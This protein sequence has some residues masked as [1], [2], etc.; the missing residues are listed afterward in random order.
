MQNW[1]TV[2]SL[3]SG[4]AFVRD[5]ENLGT[6]AKNLIEKQQMT[7]M[8]LIHLKLRVESGKHT[9]AYTNCALTLAASQAKDG[10]GVFQYR[11]ESSLQRQSRNILQVF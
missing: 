9:A 2:V 3:A 5:A 6:A 10:K 11:E 8:G 1:S 7:F 4:I